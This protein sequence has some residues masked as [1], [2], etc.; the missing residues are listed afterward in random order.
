LSGASLSV[1]LQ[2]SDPASRGALP[3]TSGINDS[4]SATPKLA[5]AKTET[6]GPLAGKVMVVTGGSRGIG[7]MIAT[8][9][10]EAGA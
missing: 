6:N 7:R 8:G 10:L 9:L 5:N 4:I 3:C 2:A 1:T